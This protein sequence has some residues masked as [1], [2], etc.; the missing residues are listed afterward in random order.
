M[1]LWDKICTLFGTGTR[2]SGRPANRY[3]IL[4]AVALISGNGSRARLAPRNQMDILKGLSRFARKEKIEICA[5][6]E[7]KPLRHAPDSERFQDTVMVRYTTSSGGV[8]DLVQRLIKTNGRGREVMV[9]TSDAMVER[10]VNDS[11]AMAMR[12]ET[13]RKALETAGVAMEDKNRG[14]RRSNRGGKRSTHSQKKPRQKTSRQKKKKMDDNGVSDL[15][16]LVEEE[17][18]PRQEAPKP[19]QPASPTGGQAEEKS[20]QPKPQEQ[21]P[22]KPDPGETGGSDSTEDDKKTPPTA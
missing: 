8:P 2:Q 21:K 22:D 19:E 10:V 6:F 1:S 5:V 3:Y 7:G 16:D 11:G 13:F 15:I 20:E 12:G 17:P 4:D 14:K 18:K 9:I